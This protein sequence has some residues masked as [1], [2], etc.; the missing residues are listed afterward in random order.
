MSEI[1]YPI[2]MADSIA[3]QLLSQ[4]KEWVA[5]QVAGDPDYFTNL[6]KG[7]QP[8]TL[9]FGCADSRVPANV[10][11][12][13]MAGELFVHRNIANVLVHDDINMLSVLQYSVEVLKVEHIIVCGHYGCGGVSAAISNAD[14]GLINKWLRFIKDVYSDHES[15]LRMMRSKEAI[16]RRMV[17]LNVMEGVHSLAKT[18]ILQ[19]AWAERGGPIIHGWVYD[20]ADGI[21]RDLEVDTENTDNLEEVFKFDLAE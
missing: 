14:L 20:L 2:G 1:R 13:T 19:K 7:Q 4:N 3:Q 21:L 5:D 18:S 11:T 8:H 15:D 12:K 6:A 9:W 10:I 16:A 17:E